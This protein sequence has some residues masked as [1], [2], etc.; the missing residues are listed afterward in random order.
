MQNSEKVFKA[1][2]YL[3]THAP[4]APEQLIILGSGLG[5]LTDSLTIKQSM[6]YPEIPGFTESTI[7]GH[8]SFL[9]FASKGS[10]KI[11]ILAGRNHLYEGFSPD[12]IVLPLRAIKLLGASRLVITNAA[13]ALNPLFKVPSLMI[14]SD[15]INFTGE[16]PLCGPNLNAWGPRFPDMSRVYSR[17]LIEIA[18]SGAL[19]LGILAH[20]GVYIGI[21]GPNLET[22]AE[23][24]AF[25]NLGADAIGM[26]TVLE[27][28]A[29]AH[30]GMEILGISCLTNKNLPDCMDETSHE[31]I[32]EQASRANLDLGR[33]LSE[34]L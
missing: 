15:H 22:P 4:F 29:A 6:P 20:E 34:I 27:S 32:L 10:R 16:S 23:T 33:L 12:E 5:R 8:D 13:G 30:M 3:K 9:H 11:A 21:K 26:S 18:Q 7:I 2:E 19:K 31:Q 1:V 14:I 17:K 28:I 25:R 24:R